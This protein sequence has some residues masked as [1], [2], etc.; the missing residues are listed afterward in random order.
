METS[1]AADIRP[2]KAT[3]RNY[4][5]PARFVPRMEN[6]PPLPHFCRNPCKRKGLGQKNPIRPSKTKNLALTG[7]F[8]A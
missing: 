2:R 8:V 7:D 1:C 6:T 4:A 5:K 3:S